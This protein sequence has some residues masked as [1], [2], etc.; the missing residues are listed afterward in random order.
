MNKI[1]IIPAILP[2][3]WYELEDKINLIA[4]MVKNVQIDI[5]DGQFV[6]N[7]TWPYRK[8]DDNFEKIKKEEIGLP[9]WQ[10]LD[11]EFDL[12]INYKTGE[13]ALDWVRAGAK[14]VIIHNKSQGGIE[15]II[16]ALKSNVEIGLAIEV[17]EDIS[18]IEKFKDSIG[19]VQCMGIDRIGFQGQ[20]FDVEV[21]EKIRQIRAKY[22]DIV[23]AIDGGVTIQNA[24]EIIEAGANRLIVGSGIFGDGEVIDNISSFKSMI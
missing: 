18:V 16:S 4:G 13:E 21:I 23:I 12:M 19:S 1:E 14:R 8:T 3:D 11:Y 17:D 10:R 2:K 6:Q 7:A 5:C 24:K 22:A 9:E 15:N 20:R